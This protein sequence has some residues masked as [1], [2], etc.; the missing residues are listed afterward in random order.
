MEIKTKY[1]LK[2]IFNYFLKNIFSTFVMLIYG[3]LLWL[4][5]QK[6]SLYKVF[7]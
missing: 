1:P 6:S 5:I 4:R 3:K 2:I 7:M